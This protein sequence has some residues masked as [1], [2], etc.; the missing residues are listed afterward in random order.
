MAVICLSQLDMISAAKLGNLR[1]MLLDL[2]AGL[3][4]LDL[5]A[6]ALPNANG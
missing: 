2:S 5:S 1:L 4:L 6:A 3:I